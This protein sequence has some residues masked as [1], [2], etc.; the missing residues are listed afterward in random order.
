MSSASLPSVSS[1]SSCVR[2][3]RVGDESTPSPQR[4]VRRALK[5]RA[6][7]EAAPRLSIRELIGGKQPTAGPSGEN[8]PTSALAEADVKTVSPSG[9]GVRPRADPEYPDFTPS[10]L[11]G[12]RLADVC[13]RYGVGS[14][15]APRE[16]GPTERVN[17]YLPGEISLLVSSLRFGLR[18]PLNFFY[19][20]LFHEYDLLPSQLLPNSYRLIT[21]F[22][23]ICRAQQIFPSVALFHKIFQIVPAGATTGWYYFRARLPAFAERLGVGRALSITGRANS[24]L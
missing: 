19:S 15:F 7:R 18:L 1:D 5:A 2:V 9:A 3:R 14:A 12:H 8:E 17:T 11:R 20:N 13:D 4:A 23:H 22:L 21:G 10:V 24:F 6:A 16:A